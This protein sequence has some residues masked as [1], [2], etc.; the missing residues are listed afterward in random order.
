VGGESAECVASQ[1]TNRPSRR[2][3]R[4]G[5]KREDSTEKKEPAGHRAQPPHLPSGLQM[6]ASSRLFGGCLLCRPRCHV[7]VVGLW[8]SPLPSIDLQDWYLANNTTA[9]LPS[10]FSSSSSLWF[11]FVSHQNFGRVRIEP[12]RFPRP[13]SRQ[14]LG[15]IFL[16]CVAHS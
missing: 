3:G 9:V 7:G 4:G 8:E 15:L 6:R 13:Q 10:S 1:Q 5:W 11:Q 12:P 16:R 14:P 2:C